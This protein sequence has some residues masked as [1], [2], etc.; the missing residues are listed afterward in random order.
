MQLVQDGKLGADTAWRVILAASMSNVVFKAA[1]AA[2][3][4]NRQL[5]TKVGPFFGTALVTGAL[6]LVFWPR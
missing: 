3:L 1:T 6:I 4:G 5:L 2:V